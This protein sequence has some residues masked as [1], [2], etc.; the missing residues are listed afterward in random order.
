MRK[1][2]P[3]AAACA[4]LLAFGSAQAQ[5]RTAPSAT[6]FYGELGYSGLRARDSDIGFNA[7]PKAIRGIVGYEF[8]PNLAVEG[9]AA[10]GVHDGSDRGVDV[11]LS[12]A[13]G[14]FLKPKIDWNN[15]EAFA[16]VGWA[17]ERLRASAPGVSATGSGSDF[18]WGAGA[19]YNINPRT[20]VSLDYMR[21][22]DKDRTKIDGWTLGV[23]YRF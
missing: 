1:L 14:V 20:Y 9:M 8:H 23:G 18:A 12:S 13:Y 6:P 2:I 16:R 17:H 15:F 10:F 5:L 19:A 11:K 7:N 22:Y 4:A 21:L 3:V